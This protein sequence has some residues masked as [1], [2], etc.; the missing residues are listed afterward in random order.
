[1]RN[2]KYANIF[3][4]STLH[5]PR[6]HSS[7]ARHD[8]FFVGEPSQARR[9]NCMRLPSDYSEPVCNAISR[10]YFCLYSEGPAQVAA[11]Q[12][13]IFRT[14]GDRCVL[15]IL[16]V[17]CLCMLNINGGTWIVCRGE[18]EGVVSGINESA[19]ATK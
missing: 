17:Q 7:D 8:L 9:D 5:T 1:M 4:G 3:L 6:P 19:K 12:H 15:A 16:A 13:R 11:A 10:A 18:H 14:T 2:S